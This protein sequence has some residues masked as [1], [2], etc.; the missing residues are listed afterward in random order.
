[1][2]EETRATRFKSVPNGDG[3]CIW[4]EAGVIDYK[5]CNNYFNCHTCAFDRAM[6]ETAA[7]NLQA[8]LEGREL[9]GKKARI[10]PWKET[11]KKRSAAERKCRHTLSGRAPFRL[12][13]YDYECHQCPFDQMLE[14]GWELQIP[15]HLTNIPVVEGYRLPEG[16]FFH[17][18]HAWARIEHGGRMRIGLDDFSMRLFGPVDSLELPLSGEEVKFS[19]V[20]LS[21]KRMGKEASVLSP[22]SGIVSSVNYRM[23]KEPTVVR[24]EPYNEGW[25]LVLEPV[26]MKKNL[27]DLLF[28]KESTE[29]IKEEHDKLVEMV[30]EVGI[31]YA[32]G[33]PVQDVVGKVPDLTWE[34]LTAEFL[35]T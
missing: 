10:V 21:F 20:G 24:D 1:M 13:P 19:E 9:K 11:M 15:Y 27:K 32:D 14:D 18:G 26:E 35:H 8:R 6:R 25:L 33:G 28:G 5:L 7:K 17:L 12:C 29:W 30:S 23:T 16:H 4:M 22:L 34:R 3:K 31:A 2:K